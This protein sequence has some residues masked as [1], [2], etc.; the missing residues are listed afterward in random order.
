[1]IGSSSIGTAKVSPFW[2]ISM[3]VKSCVSLTKAEWGRG[4]AHAPCSWRRRAHV[5]EHLKLHPADIASLREGQVEVEMAAGAGRR[6][7]RN[8]D[9]GA[10]LRDHGRIERFAAPGARGRPAAS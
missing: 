9:G 6:A 5:R 2:P 4:A 7:G 3:T 1:M 10:L 8:R